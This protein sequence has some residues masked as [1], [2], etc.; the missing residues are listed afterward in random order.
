MITWKAAKKGNVIND[1]DT[2]DLAKKCHV[3]NLNIGEDP[4]IV[5]IARNITTSPYNIKEEQRPQ[6]TNPVAGHIIGSESS[7]IWQD[8]LH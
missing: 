2:K 4:T 1:V 7:S 8:E 5:I 3:K 6:S